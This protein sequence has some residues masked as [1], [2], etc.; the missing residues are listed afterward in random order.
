VRIAVCALVVA[1]LVAAHGAAAAPRDR[2][3]SPTGDYCTSAERKAGAVKLSVS[4][5]SFSGRYRLCVKPTTAAQTCKSFPLRRRGALW[6][7][8]VTWYKNFPN[9]GTGLYRVTWSYGSIRL[10]PPLTFA[11][12]NS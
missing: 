6:R 10:G 12:A 3:C 9:R 5:F 8:E 4:T 2:Y 1:S 11:V 7:S